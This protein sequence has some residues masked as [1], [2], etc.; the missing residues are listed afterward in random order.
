[1]F[2]FVPLIKLVAAM[3]SVIVPAPLFVIV[4]AV[5]PP[6][7]S[8]PSVS[9]VLAAGVNVALPVSVVAPNVSPAVP[10]V[11]LLPAVRLSVCTPMFS[12]PSVCVIPAPLVARS[13]TIVEVPPTFVL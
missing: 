2:T 4:R 6:S 8:A 3:A 10:L 11:T 7:P 12:G 13:E 9:S 5:T 1:M